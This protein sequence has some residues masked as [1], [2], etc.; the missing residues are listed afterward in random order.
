MAFS[1]SCLVASSS[2]ITHI[3][4]GPDNWRLIAQKVPSF[5]T[6]HA[7]FCTVI[8]QKLNKV[9]NLIYLPSRFANKVSCCEQHEAIM[10]LEEDFWSQLEHDWVL[11]SQ[12]GMMELLMLLVDDC[13]FPCRGPKY[14]E[15][16]ADTEHDRLKFI[17]P[18]HC[19]VTMVSVLDKGN[20]QQRIRITTRESCGALSTEQWHFNHANGVLSHEVSPPPGLNMPTVN[21]KIYFRDDRLITEQD[22]PTHNITVKRTWRRSAI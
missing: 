18:N 13:C 14:A 5:N 19:G 1:Q 15:I 20:T 10:F 17:A 7:H 4:T 16:L 3:L 8:E 21:K 12:E 2:K 22:Y 9:L 6:T 11:E